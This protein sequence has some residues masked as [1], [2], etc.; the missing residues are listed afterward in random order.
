VVGQVCQKCLL[1]CLPN[2]SIFIH[3]LGNQPENK[4]IPTLRPG[5]DTRYWQL[6]SDVI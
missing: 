2:I 6:L 4:D 5:P 3:D 1:T